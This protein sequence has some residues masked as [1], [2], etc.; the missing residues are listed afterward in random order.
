M[1]NWRGR[2]DLKETLVKI[3]EQAMLT[4]ERAF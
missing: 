3:R 4:S 1:F 2:K